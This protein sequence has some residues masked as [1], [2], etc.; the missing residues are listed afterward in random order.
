VALASRSEQ[1]KQLA[2]QYCDSDMD[3]DH[4]AHKRGEWDNG[5]ATLLNHKLVQVSDDF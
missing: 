2:R 4:R 3:T 1:I 5:R